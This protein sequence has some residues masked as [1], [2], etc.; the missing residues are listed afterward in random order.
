MSAND[1][2]SPPA[3]FHDV[4][5]RWARGTPTAYDNAVLVALTTSSP[6]PHP[7]DPILVGFDP[8]TRLPP[9]QSV[10]LF[11]AVKNDVRLRFHTHTT[12]SLAT[13]VR[14]ALSTSVQHTSPYSSAPLRSST[15][16]PST[17]AAAPALLG[18]RAATMSAL[19]A[20]RVVKWC[21]PLST[22]ENAGISFVTATHN[23]GWT[24]VIDVDG[25][26]DDSSDTAMKSSPVVRW[27]CTENMTDKNI[28]HLAVLIARALPSSAA[29]VIPAGEIFYEGDRPP[30]ARASLPVRLSLRV[31]VSAGT[32]C[33]LFRVCVT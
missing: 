23:A 4:C 13:A 20:K 33:A 28:A 11:H 14:T 32:F 31:Y 2:P 16:F 22:I 1:S 6:L 24:S 9:A 21:V 27:S 3:F 17:L 15:Q 12:N 10:H 26:G 5:E 29:G 25:C 30:S 7:Y 18:L 19:G 8:Q